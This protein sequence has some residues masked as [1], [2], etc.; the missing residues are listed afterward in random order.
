MDKADALE[1]IMPAEK[2]FGSVVVKINVYPA[3]RDN[4][5]Q[6]DLF[7]RAFQGNSAVSYTQHLDT[8][9]GPMDFIVCKKDAAQFFNDQMDDINGNKTILYQDVAKDV[10]D[11]KPGVFF[12]TEAHG[13]LSKPLGEWP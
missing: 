4:E 11:S 10:F 12:C 13:S 8:V 9:F 5:T 2:N 6:A 3:N 1:K 7:Y